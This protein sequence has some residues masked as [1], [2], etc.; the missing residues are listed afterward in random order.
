MAAKVIPPEEL[1]LPNESLNLWGGVTKAI[2]GK[3]YSKAT[4]LK[5]ELEEKQREKAREREKN[6][7]TW[8]PVFFEHVVGNGGKPD[9]TEKGRLVLERA[10]KA[11]WSMEGIVDVGAQTNA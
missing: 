6:Q 7:E 8:Q 10:Q 1:Q 11:D 9:L 4:E 5:V 2:H 3:Q